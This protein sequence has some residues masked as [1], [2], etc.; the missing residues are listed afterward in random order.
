VTDREAASHLDRTGLADRL[1]TTVLS[2]V[3]DVARHL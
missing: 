3:E 2:R 1:E